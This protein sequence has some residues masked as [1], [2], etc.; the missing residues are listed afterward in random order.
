MPAPLHDRGVISRYRQHLPVTDATPVISLNEGS[1]PLIHSPRLSERAEAEV[2]IKYEGLNPTG[3]FKDRGM[4]VALSKAVEHG[5]GTVICASTGN[6]SAAAAAYAAR[7]GIQCAVLLPAG[8]IASG[9]LVQAYLYGA[10]VIAIQGNF[11]DALRLV[12]ELGGIE[13]IAIVNSINPDRIEGQKTASFEI[14]EELGEAPDL[15]ILPVGNA[16]NITAYWKGYTEFH[17]AGRSTVLP[18]MMGF[19]ASGS[20][21]IFHNQV[22]DQPNTVATAIRIG[23]PASWQGAST[24]VADSG[25]AIGIVT[26]EEILAAQRW[27]ASREGI[28]VEPASAAS[29]AG[30]FQLGKTGA[31]RIVLTVT[32]HGLKDPD[33]AMTTGTYRPVEA[34]ANLAAIRKILDAR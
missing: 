10:K 15:H 7:A 16:G 11:D 29:V 14:I 34:E 1:T 12:R 20:A 19:Q 31:R 25:G 17:A 4:T 27:L 33:T 18:R 23:N 8:K 28:F 6:T 5:A 9:K 2:F 21:P 24:A 26:D 22:V 32:G 3:S 13:G 30:L